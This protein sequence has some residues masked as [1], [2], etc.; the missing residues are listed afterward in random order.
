MFEQIFDQIIVVKFDTL[1]LLGLTLIGGTFGG[2]VFQRLKIPQVVGYIAIGI[3]MGRTGLN[4]ISEGVVRG[5]QPVS[6]FA[7]GLIGFT[8][9]GEMKNE[10]FK[11]YGRQFI[12]ILL[13]EGIA[14]FI[15]VAIFV[16]VAASFFMSV[17]AAAALGLLMGGLASATAPAA[18]MDV[19]HEYKM[20]GPLTTII[21][22]IVALDDSLALILFSLAMSFSGLLLGQSTDHF[23]AILGTI[24]EIVGALIIGFLFGIVM[25]VIMERFAEGENLLVFS[26][27]LILITLGLSHAMG[28]DM[29]LAAMAMGYYVTNFASRKYEEMFKLIG[30]FTPPIYVLFF[31]LVGAE[32]NLSDMPMYALILALMYLIARLVGKIGGTYLGALFARSKPKVLN[33]LPWCLFSQG[34]VAI[35]LSIIAGQRFTGDF[36]SII[37]LIITVTTFVFEILGPTCVKFAVQ[38]A[39]EIGLNITEEDLMNTTLARELLE[40][41]V[42]IIKLNTKIDD[43]IKSFSEHENLYYP[44]VDEHKMLIGIITID[45]IKSVVLNYLDYQKILIA[46]DLMERVPVTATVDT[47]LSRIMELMKI[48]N[49]E[50]I[51]IIDHDNKLE[52]IIEKRAIEKLISKKLLEIQR[53]IEATV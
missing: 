51:P 36:G 19:I 13:F 24:Y 1:L 5:F 28:I 48:Q 6:Y 4:I 16:G 47:Q 12:I 14:T 53:R 39:E 21:K 37:V 42:P 44:V 30:K 38:R 43:V 20:S 27:G 23:A 41:K 9:G 49:L 35:G 22:G 18:T 2:R 11:L 26:L 3:L 31:V 8:I 29:L 17:G 34:G 32:L 52:G 45:H 40:E 50:Y 46:Y 7:L 10:V 15:S 25:K 33:N